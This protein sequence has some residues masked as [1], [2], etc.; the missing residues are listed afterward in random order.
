[1]AHE[2]SCPSCGEAEDLSGAPQDDDIR[3]T[4]HGC[5]AEWMRGAPVCATC[6]GSDLVER[7]QAMTRHSRGTQLS[8]IGWRQL[9]LCRRCDA[10]ALETSLG[11][12]IPV[13][14]PYVSAALHAGGKAAPVPAAPRKPPGRTDNPAAPAAPQP[15]RSPSSVPRPHHTPGKDDGRPSTGNATGTADRP[16]RSRP[17]PART[18]VPTVGQAITAFLTEASGEADHTALVLL[19]A[20]LG[21]YNRLSVLDAESSEDWLTAWFDKRWKD[22]DSP[23]ARRARDTFC[24]AVDFWGARGWLARDPVSALR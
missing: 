4:C 5:G 6:S 15:Q 19:G 21:S 23:T 12:N 3:V 8:I 10:Q 13:P 20:Y 1:M 17:Q 24:R 11:E 16:R 22:R 7:P 2:L 9:P 14:S 18:Q